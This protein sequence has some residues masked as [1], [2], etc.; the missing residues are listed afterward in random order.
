MALM[1]EEPSSA[2]R[3][4]ASSAAAAEA[5]AEISGSGGGVKARQQAFEANGTSSPDMPRS[6]DESSSGDKISPEVT[7]PPPPPAGSAAAS[8]PTKRTVRELLETRNTPN[9]MEIGQ[10]VILQADIT[11]AELVIIRGVFEGKVKAQC[12]DIE[13][14]AE[15]KGTIECEAA[16]VNGRFDGVFVSSHSLHLASHANVSGRT[17]YRRLKVAKGAQLYGYSEYRS[18]VLAK[19]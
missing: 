3:A 2:Q 1:S 10:G 13:Q 11:G 14:G 12:I 15:V 17:I 6:P 9:K 18:P 5:A 4:S 19:K 7:A 8:I 16:R